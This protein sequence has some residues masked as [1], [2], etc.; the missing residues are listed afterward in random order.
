MPV[1]IAQATLGALVDAHGG[2]L[3]GGLSRDLL[4]RALGAAERADACDLSPVLHDRGAASLRAPAAVL[5]TATRVAGRVPEGRRWVH[6]RADLVLARLLASLPEAP[7]EFELVDGAQ[8]ARGV[9]LP[10][11]LRLEPG[12]VVFPGVRLGARVRLGAGSVVGRVGFGFVDDEQGAPLRIPHRAGVTLGDGVEIGALCTID[13]GVLAPTELGR[14]TKLDAH[15][16][17][18]HGVVLGARCRLAAQVGLAGSVA[19]EDDVWI[20]GQ[21]GIAD[22]CRVGRGARIAAKAGVIGDVPSGAIFAGY[23]AVARS[24]WLRGHAKLYRA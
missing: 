19:I 18:G 7:V 5:L 12:V 8:I 13:A 9:A 14:D 2:A 3:D 21:A 23:P 1:A 6:P 17:L 24:R 10:A 16:H 11:D 20:G 22:H 4:V 15:V